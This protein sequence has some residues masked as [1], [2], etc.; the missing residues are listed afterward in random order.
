MTRVDRFSKW[1]CKTVYR[2]TH[3]R[4]YQ[5]NKNLW[6]F[7]RVIRN[8]SGNI[9]DV[10]FKNQKINNV[11]VPAKLREKPL[12]IMATGPSVRDI[13]VDFFDDTFDYM[14]VNGAS[15]IESVNFCWYVIIDRSFVLNRLALV[16]ALVARDDLIL[17]CNYASLE[18]IF[19]HIPRQ[20]I[21]CRFKI[22]ETASSTRIRRFMD[23]TSPIE[24]NQPEHFWYNNMGFSKSV[25][26]ILFD[27]GTV[28]YPALQIAC[29]LGYREIYI[30]G[31][32]MNNFD[33]PRFYETEQ[34]RLS[35]ILD[36]DFNDICCAFTSSQYYCEQNNIRVVNLS[37]ESAISAFP[38]IRWDRVIKAG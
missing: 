30:A 29:A 8:A 10:Y 2:L 32:D 11:S 37:P 24:K 23:A 28:A 34:D 4:E 9:Q 21:R 25:E 38:K 3:S 14:G 1:T 5:H 35:T 27:Y 17:F 13:N 19:S 12:L 22:F 20:N 18:P 6:P 31:L 36:R 15:S 26:H 16:K 7:F 33:K